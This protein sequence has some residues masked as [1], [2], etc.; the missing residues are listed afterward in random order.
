MNHIFRHVRRPYDLMV[1]INVL[2]CDFIGDKIAEFVADQLLKNAE[3]VNAE[4]DDYI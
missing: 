3:R 2:I 1:E 4:G